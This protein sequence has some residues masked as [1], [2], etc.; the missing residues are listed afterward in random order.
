MTRRRAGAMRVRD[1]I[2]LAAFLVYAVPFFWQL[3][4]SLKPEAELMALPR[5][6]QRGSP[7]ST[8]GPSSSRA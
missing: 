3:L 4:T 2:V 5:S 8:T 1:W 7:A 6:S